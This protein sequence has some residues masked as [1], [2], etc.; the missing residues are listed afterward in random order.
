MAPGRSTARVRARACVLAAALAAALLATP[1][2]PAQA[3]TAGKFHWPVEGPVLRLYQ[4]PPSPYEAGHRGID[5]AAPF[6][7]VIV[8]SAKGTVSFAGWVAGSL[9]VTIQHA[10]GVRTSYSWLSGIDVVVGQAVA[11]QQPIGWTG[12][13]HPEVSTPHL[14]FSVRVGDDYVDPLLM[15][16]PGSVVGLIRLAPLDGS[17]GR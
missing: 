5:I 11:A 3:T 7:T 6:G 9:F 17:S 4:A 13:G 12:H 2:W 16:R 8:A 15:L 14:H 1:P 10:D